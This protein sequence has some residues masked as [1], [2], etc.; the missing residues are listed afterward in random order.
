[1]RKLVMALLLLATAA[2][3][4][5]AAFA[6]GDHLMLL[7][8]GARFGQVFR[9]AHAVSILAYTRQNSSVPAVVRDLE[10]Q[11]ALKEAGDKLQAVEDR[12]ALNE[13]LRTGKYDVLLADVTD[14]EVLKEQVR[15]APSTP[16]VLPVVFESTKAEETA[17]GK[18]FQCVLKAPGKADHYMAAIDKAM[19]LKLKGGASNSLR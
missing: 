14:A 9:H 5:S 18:K 19:E 3:T 8:R 16:I 15:T 17:V 10:L 7:A 6:C 4:V 13:A 12:T 1:M 2:L 11:P